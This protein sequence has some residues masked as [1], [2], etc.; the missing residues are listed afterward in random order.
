MDLWNPLAPKFTITKNKPEI[1]TRIKETNSNFLLI[2]QVSD[3]G[4]RYVPN[5]KDCGPPTFYYSASYTCVIQ[6]HRVLPGTPGLFYE[7]LAFTLKPLTWA[8]IVIMLVPVHIFKLGKFLS[9][10]LKEKNYRTHSFINW[11]W[12]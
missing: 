10:K 12:T 4:Q 11:V 5:Y 7:H 8:I 2:A 9:L 3:R 1:N 6:Y